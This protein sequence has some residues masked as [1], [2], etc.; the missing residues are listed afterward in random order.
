M[1][2]VFLAAA[3]ASRALAQV[4]NFR[5]V[6]EQ[7]L[8]NPSPNDWLMFSRTFDAQRFSPLNQ[9]NLSNVAQLRT[10]W[11]R[12]LGAGQTETIPIVMA[13]SGGPLETGVIAGLGRPGGNV[14]GLSAIT[15]ELIGKRFE[16]LKEALPGLR[17]IAF[18]QNMGNPV[19]PPQW[20]EL[21]AIAESRGVEAQLLDLRKLEDVALMI[22]AASRQR[23]ALVVGNDSV[24]HAS[25]HRIVELAT[26]HQLA[27]VYAAR[28]FVDAG[29]LMSY[30]VSYSDHYRRAAV[31]VDKIFR[32][33]KPSDLPVEQPTKF[34]LV[35]NLKTAK[36]IGLSI[37]PDVLARADR[38]IR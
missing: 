30:A 20:E 16:L 10:A 1:T 13:A 29:G 7:E 27:T 12:G 32:G 3:V 18:L 14:T 5:P 2:R 38:V 6:T 34:D 33:A 17:R 15:G 36:E 8:R 26:K 37:P 11:V 19:A 22:D 31:F 25:R 21:K 24:T 4:Q 35:I 9:I 23:A 28:E